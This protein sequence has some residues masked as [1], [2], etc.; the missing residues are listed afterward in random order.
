MVVKKAAYGILDGGRL[1]YLKLE[2]KLQDLGLHKVHAEGAVFSYVKKNKLHGLVVSHVDDLLMIGDSKFQDEV[3]TKLSEFFKLSKVESGTFN[4]CGCR[5][6]AKENGDIQVDQNEYV[7]KIQFIDIDE[8]NNEKRKLDAKE[9]KMLRG[10]IGEILW[11]SLMTRPDLSF[12]V[13]RIATEVSTAT[14]VTLREMNQLIKRAKSKNE[15]LNF[16]KLGDVKNLKVK[17]YTDA[18]YNNL[19]EKTKSTEGRVILVENSISK[20]L[21]VVSW[22]TKKIPRVCRSVKSAET[23]SLDDGLDDAIHI[24]RII[25]EIYEGKINL[26]EPSQIPVIAKTDS[27]SLWESL[28]NSRQC[29]EKLLWSTIAGLKELLS[30]GY[31]ESVDWVSTNWQLADSLTKKCSLAKYDWLLNVAS[32]NK[33]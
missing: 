1:F 21:S 29:E 2:E 18:S 19:N 10:K 26:K 30:L 22:K 27:K 12:E 3:E 23:R 8:E 16:S 5:I 11:I 17:V 25:K 32:N 9:Q 14:V 20:K 33:L 13:N 31:V 15:V 28:N 7:N 24:A 4:Y 6:S